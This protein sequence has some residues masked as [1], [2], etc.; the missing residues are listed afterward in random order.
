V[1]AVAPAGVRAAA[2]RAAV[3]ALT[4][5]VVR[6]VI[7]TGPA[8]HVEGRALTPVGAQLVGWTR[9]TTSAASGIVETTLPGVPVGEVVLEYRREDDRMVASVVCDR[10]RVGLVI[11][12]I[13]QSQTQIAFGDSTS[14]TLAPEANTAVSFCWMRGGG[15]SWTPPDGGFLNRQ[16]Q[17]SEGMVAAAR[18]LDA[19]GTD[20]PVEFLC[21]AQQGTSLTQMIHRYSGDGLDLCG[22]GA[23]PAS[24]MLTAMVL[25]KRRRVTGWLFSWSTS[26]ASTG[27]GG[28]H[29]IG[30]TAY[31]VRG[32]LV[33]RP[34]AE[35][36]NE[37]F[38]GVEKAS[39]DAAE[40]AERRNLHDLGFAPAW[41]PWVIMLPV[42]R[43]RSNIAGPAPA[44]TTYGLFRQQQYELAVSG[45]GKAGAWECDLGALQI[46][47]VMP[48]AE[49]AHQ[50]RTDPRGNIRFCLRYAQ[51]LAFAGKLSTLDPRVAFTGATRAGVVLTLAAALPNGGALVAQTDGAA[52]HEFEV[53]ENGGSTWSRADGAIPFTA[54]LAGATVTLTRSSGSWA[55]NTQV[56]YL[57]GWPVAVGGT[58]S[59]T[60]AARL[61]GLL[62]ETRPDAIPTGLTGLRAGIPL[63][64]TWT[65]VTEG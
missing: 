9:V 47:I 15:T 23:D 60:E 65:P 43:H 14:V 64:P 37:F 53:S 3:K 31:G 44:D 46:D 25:A 38:G 34:S 59:A 51:A 54:A 22:D 28:S 62:Y 61:D 4:G 6:D 36:M 57:A 39:A 42:S 11:S 24:G 55:A 32:P 30:Q 13:G 45:A 35:R 27:N 21:V 40:R 33:E 19:L 48:N 58:D 50:D 49:T 5:S 8:T 41:S 12:L 26:D 29:P 7:V 2:N 52:L 63:M 18:M 56:R 17:T 20:I 1:H 16:R 10:E